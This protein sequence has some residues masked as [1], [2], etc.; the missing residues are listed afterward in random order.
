MHHTVNFLYV[1]SNVITFF[2]QCGN[3]NCTP[4][5]SCVITMFYN[6]RLWHFNFFSFSLNIFW[7]DWIFKFFLILKEYVERSCLK[8]KVCDGS[9]ANSKWRESQPV[10]SKL[11]KRGWLNNSTAL[12]SLDF[13]FRNDTNKIN[14]TLF[15]CQR[16]SSCP[17]IT[18]HYII[19]F[20]YS[21]HICLPCILMF[22][23]DL[24][25]YDISGEQLL[26]VGLTGI[27]SSFGPGGSGFTLHH[28]GMQNGLATQHTPR[29][30]LILV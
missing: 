27:A 6:C 14:S 16:K 28:L 5:F 21:L 1:L 22:S 19:L 7:C 20:S 29:C 8:N 3:Q 15:S 23:G 2:L 26:Q 4:Y 12:F 25:N 9:S 10:H 13:M 24:I 18:N 30:Y 17:S 11:L